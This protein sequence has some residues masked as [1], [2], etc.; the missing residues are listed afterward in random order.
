MDFAAISLSNYL[1][2]WEE[3]VRHLELAAQ[4]DFV[5]ALYNPR[6]RKSV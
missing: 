2:P 4:G 6:S 5:I 3:I 1:I